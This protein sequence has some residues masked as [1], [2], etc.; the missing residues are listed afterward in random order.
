LLEL[1]TS[2]LHV[3]R[4]VLERIIQPVA[5]ASDV[6]TAAAPTSCRVDA[7][8][9]DRRSAEALPTCRRSRDTRIRA[10]GYS[11]H[12]LSQP[13]TPDPGSY[14]VTPT[15]LHVAQAYPEH[16]F[17]AKKPALKLYHDHA[18]RA[19]TA[20]KSWLSRSTSANSCRSYHNSLR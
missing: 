2:T 12:L 6:A 9:I 10:K 13:F 5:M 1:A 8:I 18:N 4:L 17:C 7:G 11:S 16:T 19:K 14:T 20:L 3:F 15:G